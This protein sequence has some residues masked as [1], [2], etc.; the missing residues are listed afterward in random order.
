MNNISQNSTTFDSNGHYNQSLLLNGSN[1]SYF[2]TNGFYYLGVSNYSYSISLW[3]YAFNNSGI[4]IQL[5]SSGNWCVSI[6]GFDD[7]GYLTAQILGT[8][9]LYSITYNYTVFQLNTW[10]CVAMTYSVTNGIRLYVNGWMG[11]SSNNPKDYQGNGQHCTI[12]LG[13]SL[14]GYSCFVNETII[15]RSQFRGKIDELKIFS[16]ELTLAETLQSPSLP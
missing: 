14:N 9:G 12:T 7:K 8:N 3:I 10:V 5:G 15:T 4:I 11:N 1:S 13:N 16:C 6:L 2:Q